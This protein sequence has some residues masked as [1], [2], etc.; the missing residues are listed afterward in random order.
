MP[1]Y[2][3]GCIIGVEVLKYLPIQNG[4]EIPAEFE[5]KRL[6]TGIGKKA[7]TTL[8]DVLDEGQQYRRMIRSGDARLSVVMKFARA[9]GYELVLIERG[10]GA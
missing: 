6:E 4:N 9:L 5:R 2:E 1:I 3:T 8:T 10:P 7:L